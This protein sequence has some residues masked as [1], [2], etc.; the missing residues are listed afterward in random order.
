MTPDTSNSRS[1]TPILWGAIIV[2]ILA[3][4]AWYA[5]TSNPESSNGPTPTPLTELESDLQ[6]L[7]STNLDSIDTELDANL[8]DSAQF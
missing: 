3:I 8:D 7:D 5:F 4:A 2:I 1:V 6:E